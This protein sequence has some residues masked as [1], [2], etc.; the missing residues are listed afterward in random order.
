MRTRSAFYS[1]L[2]VS[3]AVVVVLV[4]A[5]IGRVDGE[6][7]RISSGNAMTHPQN[8]GLAFF[9]DIVEK[10]TS[11]AL[12]VRIYPNSQLG[13]ERESVEQVKNRSLEMAT[14]SAGPLTTFNEDMMVMDVPFLFKNYEIAWIVLDGP[15]GEALKKTFERRG[16]KVLGFMENGF[17][18]I[19]NNVR[20]VHKP[21]DLKGIKIR[22]M[23]APMHMMNFRAWGANPTPVPWP[24]L[25]MVLQQ[26][27]VD[28]QENPLMNMWEV[29]F[30]E[31]Q[32]YC[33][34][35]GHIYDPM[36]LV[37]NMEW[38]DKLSPEQQNI[39]EMAGVRAQN[40]SR[41]VNLA[42]ERKLQGMLQ[43]KGMKVNP[44]S[45]EEKER[46]KELS[47]PGALKEV[48]ATVDL[49][50]LKLWLDSIKEAE[51]LVVSGL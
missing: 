46:F 37:A 22:T 50:F 19:T 43:D 20:P 3:V 49:R 10:E 44:V 39:L 27:I 5:R 51:E 23:E 2:A 17:R 33:S 8:V 11:G 34:L 13:G 47:Q 24:E 32:K 30:Y 6:D 15:G 28:G 7:V 21:E 9:K 38:F 48:Q 36:P 26:K 35:S 45:D 12:K 1:A 40:R 18:H 29:K 16:L 4:L 41:F 42:R 14:A 25:Y 31:V